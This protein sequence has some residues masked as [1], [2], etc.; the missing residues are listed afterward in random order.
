MA[1]PKVKTREP[2]M[3]PPTSAAKAQVAGFGGAPQELPELLGE[4]KAAAIT[5]GAAPTLVPPTEA[6]IAAAEEIGVAA[7]YNGKKISALWCNQANRNSYIAVSD[8]GWK[9]LANTNDSCV[10]SMTMLA[11]HAEQTNATVNIRTEEDGMV[12][13][14]YVW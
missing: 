11:A 6:Q 8:L 3:D 14:I 4:A 1:T 13:E 12:H 7:W 5:A 9:K 2:E 10:V